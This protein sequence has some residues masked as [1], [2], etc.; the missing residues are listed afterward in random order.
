MP[1]TITQNFDLKQVAFSD[2]ALMR[3]VGLLVRERVVRRTRQG[4][5]A[6]G[7]PFQPYALG[8]AEQKQ[9]SLQGTGTVNLAVSGAMLNSLQLVEV[10]NTR[11]VVGY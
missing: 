5:S 7:A 2:A 9:K 6:D 8:Y 3:E 10:T 11:V 4:I 1:V